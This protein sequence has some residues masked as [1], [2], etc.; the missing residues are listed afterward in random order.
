L[1]SR[2]LAK[3]KEERRKENGWIQNLLN[4]LRIE[5]FFEVEV[6][7]NLILQATAEIT[8]T[9]PSYSLSTQLQN[10]L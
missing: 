2:S 5:T 10:L 1:L 4:S 8:T 3:K 7:F 9:E 6:E